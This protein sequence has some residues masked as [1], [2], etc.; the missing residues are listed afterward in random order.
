M[1]D[2]NW[3][4]GC[5]RKRVKMSSLYIVENDP[6]GQLVYKISNGQ[7]CYNQTNG[8]LIYA[9]GRELKV[10]N[11]FGIFSR[12]SYNISQSR[13][14]HWT[15]GV[16][17]YDSGW[18]AMKPTCCEVSIDLYDIILNPNG[19]N[20]WIE[21]SRTKTTTITCALK[22][23]SVNYAWSDNDI[24]QKIGDWVVSSA[25]ST[26]YGSIGGII[27]TF[28]LT[29][30]ANLSTSVS[31][32]ESASGETDVGD[33]LD[34]QIVETQDDERYTYDGKLWGDLYEYKTATLTGGI[35]NIYRKLTW[36]NL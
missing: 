16:V 30:N 19:N 36:S 32:L 5:S 25:P 21:A 26:I 20:S 10:K 33:G 12:T 3:W 7:L 14:R 4:S 8:Q 34:Y 1:D 27:T 13:N 35:P 17:D 18:V 2:D 28:V 11:A 15:N 24:K 31:N 23:E 6:N 22:S 29:D 9:N